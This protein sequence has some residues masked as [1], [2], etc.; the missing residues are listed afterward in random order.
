L[1]FGRKIGL[2][3]DMGRFHAF[4]AEPEGDGGDINPRLEEMGGGRVS[5][6][7]RAALSA[8]N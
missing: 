5:V 2:Q 6:M 8:L 7:P 4:M 1:L 3:V